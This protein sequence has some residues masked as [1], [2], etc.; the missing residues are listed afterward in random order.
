MR[1]CFE[2]GGF[3]WKTVAEIRKAMSGSKGPEYFNRHGETFVANAVANHGFDAESALALWG[4]LVTFGS[5][6]MNKSHTVSYGIISYWCGWLKAYK[7]LEYAAALLR[8]AKD[9]EQTLEVLRELVAEG[10]TVVPFDR[11]RSREHWRVIDGQLIGG[12]RNLHGFGP[13]KAR[14]FVLARDSGTWEDKHTKAIEKAAIKFADL[15]PAHTKYG[16]M[17]DKPWKFNVNG[18]IKEIGDLKDKENAVIIGQVKEVDRRDEN[19]AIRVQRRG[20]KQWEGNSLFLD[21]SVVD[22]SVSKPVICRLRPEEWQR[23]GEKLADGLVADKDWLLL[24][25]RWLGDFNMM[26][27]KKVRCLTNEEILK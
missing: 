18:D 16:E 11:D 3:D 22:D 4:K 8:K 23:T 1:M 6:G 25:G 10:L 17:Y 19:E 12:F 5:W 14:N 20:N 24:R 2:I 26:I 27:V 15:R 13:V 9:D 21:I 7:P